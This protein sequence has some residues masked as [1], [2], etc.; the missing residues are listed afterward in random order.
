MA[1]QAL[2]LTTPS[3]N[4]ID[5]PATPLD[6]VFPC[7]VRYDFGGGGGGTIIDPV[8]PPAPT[9]ATINVPLGGDIQ[10]AINAA[11]PGDRILLAAGTYTVPSALTIAKVLTLQ[12]AGQAAT[13]V[14]TAGAAGDPVVLLTISVSNV[15]VR[16][17]T[18]KQRKTLNTSQEAAVAIT[19]S[20]GSSGHFLEAVTVETMEFG[21]TVKSDGWQINNCHLAYVGPNNGNRRLVGIYRSAGQGLFTNSTYNSGQNGIITGSTQVVIV[22]TGAAPPDEVLGGYLRIGYITPSNAFPVHQLFQCGYFAPSATPLTLCVDNCNT[23]ANGSTG[24]TS[25]FVVFVTPSTQPPLAQCAQINL[26]SNTLS[27]AH[28]KGAVALDGTT[29]SINNAGTTTFYASGN[30]ITSTAF[31]GPTWATA[32]SGTAV[33]AELAQMGYRTDRWVFPN[34]T[35]T[36]PAGLSG[37]FVVDGVTLLDGYRVFVVDSGNAITSGIYSANAGAWYRS[38]DMKAGDDA[39]GDRFTVTQGTTYAGTNWVC[40]NSIGNGIVGTDPL[41]FASA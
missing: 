23:K 3:T 37:L 7:N 19:A 15:V 12:G 1:Y 17:L 30:T 27:N 34:E 40:T 11:A 24:E 36:A 4:V 35:I 33:P 20:T 13:I 21:V 26:Q 14:Q 31:L 25:A 22:T 10:T 6:Y 39:A 9:G 29:A 16:D 2:S 41:V 18:L 28:G 8:V 38:Q 5:P 32:I